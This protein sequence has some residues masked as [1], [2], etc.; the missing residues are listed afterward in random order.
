MNGL[1][2]AGI[3]RLGIVQM[4]LGAI[5]V[6]MT[7]T[8]NRV[9]AVELALPAA[10]PGFLVAL[11]Y[12]VQLSRPRFGHGSDRGGRRTPWIVGG[13]LMLACGG[14]LASLATWLMATH[15]TLGTLLAAGA[16]V[17]IGAGVGASGTSLLVLL[18]SLVAPERRAA[19]AAITWLMMIFG[20]ALTAGVVGQLL[21]PFSMPRLVV[22]TGAVGALACVATV[23]AV[24]RVEPPGPAPAVSRADATDTTDRHSFVAAVREVLSEGQTRRFALF[25]FISMFAY[26]AQDL[27]LEPFAGAVFGMTPG[28]STSL[29]GMVHGG[30]L[31]GMIVAGIVGRL[32]P[33]ALRGSMIA[34]CLGSAALLLGLALAGQS[35]GA[36]SLTANVF[37]LGFANG[38]FTIAAVGSMFHLVSH[39]HAGRDGVRMG[40]WGAAQAMAFGIGGI[41]GTGAVDIVRWASTDT[42]LAYS[43]VFAGQAALFIAAA[44]LAVRLSKNAPQPALK[45]AAALN[46]AQHTH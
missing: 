23:L 46:V 37:A 2:W 12:F 44:W 1:S 22:I 15:R 29:G 8:L 43:L 42:A 35:P 31:L 41:A 34:G 7:S 28:Q 30:A 20:L 45:R 17:L 32:L 14:L 10:L 3:A 24:R 36:W 11:H 16:F 39:G 18:A 38:V 21:D 6:L 9:I 25:V 19:A 27:V 26:S 13:M 4:S 33:G 40:V 5:V